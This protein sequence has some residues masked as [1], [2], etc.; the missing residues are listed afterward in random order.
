MKFPGMSPAPDHEPGITAQARTVETRYHGDVYRLLALSL[1]IIV[2]CARGCDPR[3]CKRRR[4]TQPSFGPELLH[5]SDAITV[6][7]QDVAL[8]RCPVT[9]VLDRGLHSYESDIYSFGIVV[10]E[11]LTRQLPWGKE[12]SVQRIVW[13]VV[14]K[15]QRPAIPA[16][17][18]RDLADVA[19]ACWATE[20]SLRPNF[21]TVTQALTLHESE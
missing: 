8:A 1:P 10:W 4:A 6:A 12:E 7:P 15:E 5:P 17:A 11:V 16:G 19:R 3:V 13:R 2:E 20:P 9:Q 18:P 14:I 21:S